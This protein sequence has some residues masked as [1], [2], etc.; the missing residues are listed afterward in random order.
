MPSIDWYSGPPPLPGTSKQEDGFILISTTVD[1]LSYTPTEEQK[2]R[3]ADQLQVTGRRS[4][5][6]LKGKAE[7]VW[8]PALEAAL[9]KALEL[10]EPEK[11]GS[12]SGRAAVRYPM[13]NKFISDYIFEVTNKKRTPKQVG[14]RLQQLRDTCKKDKILQLIS[15]RGTPEP[16]STSSR[17][18]FSADI[19]PSPSPPTPTV[20]PPA[21]ESS[22]HVK[23]F[24]Q[25]ELWPSPTPSIDL[26]NRSSSL[27]QTI[28]LAPLASSPSQP[29]GRL[30]R[31]KS[32]SSLLP[33]LSGHV[34]LPSPFP[35]LPQ[36]KLVVYLAG[37]TVAIHEE[38]VSLN[39]MSSPMQGTGWLY[40]SE[41]V[42][43]FWSKLGYDHDIEQYT[44]IQTLRTAIP[45]RP[46]GSDS[47]RV[48]SIVYK[49]G[50]TAD[51]SSG[52][53]RRLSNDTSY[54]S[55]SDFSS[56]STLSSSTMDSNIPYTQYAQSQPLQKFEEDL[57]SKS[58]QPRALNYNYHV[59]P[60]FGMGPSSGN[61]MPIPFTTSQHYCGVPLSRDVSEK[62]DTYGTCPQPEFGSY[63][64][65]SSNL[66]YSA[67]LS[68][69]A[70]YFQNFGYPSYS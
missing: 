11:V 9:L 3:D 18:A 24:L 59:Q 15:S 29:S 28:Q 46:S 31:G 33:F 70:F 68:N 43:N 1:E 62:Y 35:L 53:Q 42:P 52:P 48:I 63:Y 4:Y 66:N 64:H 65:A 27:P 2:S 19:S 51:T 14:S 32:S 67:D 26:A 60:S 13:R 40:S 5:K 49:F 38:I 41:L 23:I 34:Q 22:I 7:A 45:A 50:T 25:S 30:I 58:V 54:S 39:C 20:M 17:S 6:T 57:D 8:P 21:M 69:Q 37:S 55:G 47:N 44:V 12:R 61:P 56:Q 10:Y 16:T 36:S